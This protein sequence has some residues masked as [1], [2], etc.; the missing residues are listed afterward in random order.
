VTR[1]YARVIQVEVGGQVLTENMAQ[2]IGSL[3]VNAVDRMLV[4]TSEYNV[5]IDEATARVILARNEWLLESYGKTT[6]E[7]R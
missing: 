1:D 5:K 2:Y 6:V 3:I 7:I 4:V